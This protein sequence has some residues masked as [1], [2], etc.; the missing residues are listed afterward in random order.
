M[1]SWR[2]GDAASYCGVELAVEV[3]YIHI[4]LKDW[5]LLLR[6]EVGDIFVIA[7]V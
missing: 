2:N 5:I 1:D 6:R 3:M 7:A 4:S